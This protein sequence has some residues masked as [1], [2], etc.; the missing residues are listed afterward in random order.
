MNVSISGKQMLDDCFKSGW[1][2]IIIH[3]AYQQANNVYLKK[4]FFRTIIKLQALTEITYR[5]S[6]THL[7]FFM[8]MIKKTC[9]LNKPWWLVP[10]KKKI[11]Q[12]ERKIFRISR[13]NN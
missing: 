10:I 7:Q 9:T 12:R 1:F 3:S 8:R 5:I 13:K 6:E 2:I 11:K 4:Y